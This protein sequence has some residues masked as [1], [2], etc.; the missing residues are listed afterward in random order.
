MHQKRI[1][2]IGLI[3][4]A[5]IL[6]LGTAVWAVVLRSQA[7]P[8][9]PN[10]QQASTDAPSTATNGPQLDALPAPGSQRGSG[11]ATAGSSSQ[12]PTNRIT[13]G[14]VLLPEFE[15]GPLIAPTTSPEARTAIDAGLAAFTAG[16]L[17]A[18]RAHYNRA[19]RAGMSPADAANVFA[20]LRQITERTLFSNTV[21]SGEP[22]AEIVKVQPGDALERIARRHRTTHQLLQ[23]INNITDPTRLRAGQS[24]KVIKGPFAGIVTKSRFELAIY[25]GTDKDPFQ[26]LIAVY[27]VGLGRDDS[28]PTGLWKVGEKLENP[29]FWGA[30]NLPPMEA[31]DPKNPLG[32]HWIQL[33]GTRGEAA[34]RTDYGIHGTI[35][36][37]SIGK[38][39]SL[40][41][42]RMRADQVA[43]VYTLLT[44]GSTVLIRP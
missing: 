9:N 18:A 20:A 12:P 30:S 34:N 38:Q 40:G 44:R 16:D 36:P 23:R 10:N 26:T 39:T 28:T 7:D 35:E 19:A 6:S 42:V 25:L 5:A 33:V 27:P 24:V 1:L 4:L 32:E 13:D 15:H 8:D 11:A 21:T 22:Y 3:A 31:D 14:T 41:C 17:L 2:Q 43:E 37:D 29:K